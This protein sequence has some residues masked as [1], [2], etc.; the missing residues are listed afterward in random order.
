MKY[1][2]LNERGKFCGKIFLHYTD[3]MI[4][5]LGHFI[6]THPVHYY[7]RFSFMF[8]NFSRIYARN[9]CFYLNAVYLAVMHCQYYCTNG[10]AFVSARLS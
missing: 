7:P 9:S 8:V 5:V 10:G 2:V 1:C 3:I 6:D 4:F